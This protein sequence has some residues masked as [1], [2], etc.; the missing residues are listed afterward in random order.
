MYQHLIQLLTTVTSVSSRATLTRENSPSPF[1]P[2]TPPSANTDLLTAIV[3]GYSKR[4]SSQNECKC[5]SPPPLLSQPPPKATPTPISP[6]PKINQK[7]SASK[8]INSPTPNSIRR[9]PKPVITHKKTPKIKSVKKL[10]LISEKKS[11][12]NSTIKKKNSTVSSLLSAKSARKSIKKRSAIKRLGV[13]S[14]PVA[15][16]ALMHQLLTQPVNLPRDFLTRLPAKMSYQEILQTLISASASNPDVPPSNLSHL[17]TYSPPFQ[18]T[19]SVFHDH[20]ALLSK[21]HVPIDFCF[22]V[23][24]LPLSVP[25]DFYS[26]CL[27]AKAVSREH[28]YAKLWNSPHPK[29]KSFTLSL[30]RSLLRNRNGCVCD[31]KPWVF[32]TTC[33]SLY[34][35]NCT[36]ST[37]CPTCYVRLY[38]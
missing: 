3:D 1:Y 17:S 9:P 16:Q 33:H 2:Y 22:R 27:R 12:L 37:L 35:S 29:A 14:Q 30:P 18:H 6:Q 21:E 26:A 23:A 7:K 25:L 32:C 19:H 8:E 36:D 10:K 28:S 34:H 24:S 11:P 15:V 13:T 38:H 5:S 4:E 20:Y 31:G